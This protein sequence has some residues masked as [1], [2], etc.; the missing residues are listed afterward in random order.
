[1]NILTLQLRQVVGHTKFLCDAGHSLLR[2]L[3]EGSG[4]EFWSIQQLLRVA[5]CRF[6]REQHR[7]WLG[8]TENISFTH[9]EEPWNREKTQELWEHTPSMWCVRDWKNFFKSDDFRE[10][11]GV[12]ETV[13][14]VTKYR[15]FIFRR[16]SDPVEASQWAVR[17]YFDEKG[18]STSERPIENLCG[19][20][21]SVWTL[22]GVGWSVPLDRFAGFLPE[23][24]PAPLNTA[25]K[26][27]ERGAVYWRPEMLKN[28][29]TQQW[30]EEDA[31][32]PAGRA[33]HTRSQE[34]E[35]IRVPVV[36]WMPLVRRSKDAKGKQER[37]T[38]FATT[39]KCDE[40][41]EHTAL[42]PF[43]P[44]QGTIAPEKLQKEFLNEVM[45]GAP[46]GWREKNAEELGL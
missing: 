12:F 23:D 24:S 39:Q 1:M 20:L 7:H 4:E 43:L 37:H 35:K 8:L 46:P 2:A 25:S 29:V 10:R 19:E 6:R 9:Q 13:P 14:T 21:E 38:Q 17:C 33:M 44:E 15:F 41:L 16:E 34:V 32:R 30:K 27:G 28:L 31:P 18:H 26:D 22:R 36:P 40:L 45:R 3:M 5:E 11:V 42:F